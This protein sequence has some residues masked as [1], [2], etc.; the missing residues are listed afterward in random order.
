MNISYYHYAKRYFKGTEAHDFQISV[1]IVTKNSLSL[2]PEKKNAK[3]KAKRFKSDKKSSIYFKKTFLSHRQAI[4]ILQ[5][6]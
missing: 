1:F 4:P 6:P 2:E 5:V 3:E